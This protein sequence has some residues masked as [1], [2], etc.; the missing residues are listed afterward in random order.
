MPRN[1]ENNVQCARCRGVEQV[2]REG[3]CVVLPELYQGQIN[4]SLCQYN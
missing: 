1:E 2:Y 4:F 3:T